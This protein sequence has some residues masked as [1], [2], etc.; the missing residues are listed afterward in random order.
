MYSGVMQSTFFFICIDE[1]QISVFLLILSS[2][3][4]FN[5]DNQILNR[6]STTVQYYGIFSDYWVGMCYFLFVCSIF[7]SFCNFL[8]HFVPQIL[9]WLRLSALK[10]TR[11]E[12]IRCIIVISRFSKADLLAN[13][14]QTD[15]KI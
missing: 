1:W 8:S 10:I 5:W 6:G 12:Y 11:L 2:L 7:S 4:L 15:I 9:F 3:Q 13:F 14:W